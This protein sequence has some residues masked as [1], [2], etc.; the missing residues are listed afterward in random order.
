MVLLV[1]MIGSSSPCKHGFFFCA[2][3]ISFFGLENY[4]VITFFIMSR[5]SDVISDNVIAILAT[6][7][8]NDSRPLGTIQ[9][10]FVWKERFD[11]TSVQKKKKKNWVISKR[12][13]T[14][15]LRRPETWLLSKPT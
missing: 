15:N 1:L 3:V 7:L 2:E 14:N 12:K 13:L 8:V 6:C 4:K 9:A 10:M 5:G 11:A